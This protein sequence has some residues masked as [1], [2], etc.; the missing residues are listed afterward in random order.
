MNDNIK[1][2]TKVPPNLSPSGVLAEM[3]RLD[4]E[5]DPIVFGGPLKY[6]LEQ[7]ASEANC[8]PE[9]IEDVMQWIGQPVLRPRDQ[10]WSEDDVQ[11]VREVKKF[12]DSQNLNDWAMS[13]MLRGLAGS[14]ERMAL[15][16]IE[17]IIQHLV[18]ELKLN[19]THARLQAASFAPPKAGVMQ[20][21]ILHVWRR[22]YAAAA[23]RLTTEA[24]AQRGVQDDD[25]D[26]PLVRVVGFADLV[27]F[28]AR[29]E[30]FSNSEFNDLVY[31]FS[32]NAWDIVTGYGGRVI[33]LI[34]DAVYWMANDIETGAE[35]ALA[36]ARPGAICEGWEARVGLE[37]TRVMSAYGD[38]FGPGVNLAARLTSRAEPS[39]VFVG[40]AA[41]LLLARSSQYTI[42]EQP[43][44]EAKGIGT[45]HPSRL[46]YAEE[47]PTAVG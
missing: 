16:H 31:T 41:A 32:D 1:P 26:F 14:M 8:E 46:R 17:A 23:H 45:V 10:R 4:R 11:F 24:V 37:W 25:I 42:T 38:I 21:L 33:N 18:S 40:P 15:R 28:T 27:N 43:S 44:F 35:I 9:Y 20:P 19:D 34:G 7:A 47:D 36:L 12:Q 6:T 22:R 3:A 39:E 2:K 5:I 13:A 30:D 29:T